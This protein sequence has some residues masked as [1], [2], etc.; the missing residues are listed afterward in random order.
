MRLCDYRD[1]EGQFDRI[2]SIE[3]LEA[4]GH[5]YYD[6]FFGTCE[7]LL[8]PDGLVG[9]AG[10]HDPRRPLR[11][12]PAWLRLDPEAH[13]PRRS[14]AVA[15][16]ALPVH[17]PPFP[18]STWSTCTNIGPHYARTLKLWREAF[19][20]HAAEVEQLGFD[21]R[22]RRKWGYYLSYCEAA[23]ATR[24]LNTLHLVLTRARNRQLL[25][26]DE[27]KGKGNRAGGITSTHGMASS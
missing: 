4:V 8:K 16:R 26:D 27:R 6:T 9:A 1:I 23:F 7:R 11:R 13:L 25:R 18:L 5:R 10:D 17:D 14:P 20:R 12:V 22:F 2:V 3:M 19:E 21:A 15:D 24:T